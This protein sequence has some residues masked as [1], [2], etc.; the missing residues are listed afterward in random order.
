MIY[1]TRFGDVMKKYDYNNLPSDAHVFHL[2]EVMDFNIDSNYNYISQNPIYLFLKRIVYIVFDFLLKIINNVMFGYKIIDKNKAIKKSKVISVSNHIHPM[3]CTM[4]SLIYFKNLI[5][6]PTI[7]NNFKIPFIRKLIK[8]LGAIPI[9]S[10]KDDKKSFYESINNALNDNNHIHMYPE[11]SMWPYY[12]KLRNFKY[13]AFKMAVD[14][15]C[16]VQPIKFIY[17]KP[18]GIKKIY[19]R[20]DCINAIV[21]DPIYPNNELNY[22]DRINDL[23]EKAFNAIDKVVI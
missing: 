23:K 9:P 11:G 8:L 15:N 13:G 19:K 12:N 10:K 4:I 21:L 5:Y 14:A 3:D 20:K 22:Y 16:P 17:Q 6:F 18:K 7:I 2:W 1:F